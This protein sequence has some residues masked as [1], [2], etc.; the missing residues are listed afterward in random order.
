MSER[1]NARETASNKLKRQFGGRQILEICFL[2]VL[3][4]YPMRHVNVGGDLCDVGYN[5]GNFVFFSE[6][7]LGKTWFFSTYLA[8]AAGHLLTALPFGRTLMGINV[9][10]GVFVSILAIMGYLFCTRVLRLSPIASFAGEFV[11]ISMCW[12][13]TSLLYNYLTYVLFLACLILLYQGLAK[14]K[15]WMLVM[16]GACLG[17]N[18]FVRFSNLPEMG[19]IL[20]VWGFAIWEGREGHA[21]KGWFG[22]AMGKLVRYTAWCLL[23]YVG[24]LLLG[25]AWIGIRYGLSDYVTGIKLLFSMTE[26]AADYKP[27]SMIKGLIWPFWEAIYWVIRLAFFMVIALLAGLAGRYLP[28]ALPKEKRDKVKVPLAVL[29]LCGTWLANAAMVFWIFYQGKGGGHLTSFW[30]TSYDPIYWPCALFWMLALGIGLIEA[31]RPGNAK[32]NRFLGLALILIGMLTSL[33]SNNGIYPSFNNLFAFAPYVFAK[34][35]QFTRYLFRK[36][37]LSGLLPVCTTAW[38]FLVVC[39]VQ[40]ILFGWVF[41][42]C[43]STGIQNA[44][45]V[46]K[47]NRVLQGIKMNESRAIALEELSEFA[48]QQGL[49]GKEVILHGNVPA[50][51][52]YF[53][54]KPALHSWNDLKSFS[55]EVMKETMDELREELGPQGEKPV[56]IA[57][58]KYADFG[59]VAP[60]EAA[61]ALYNEKE[62]TEDLKWEL[63]RSFMGEY[64]YRKTFENDKFVVW[65]AP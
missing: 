24:I 19:L 23:G 54:M 55:Y 40:M 5:Y 43:E 30:Y 27:V 11:A 32:E 36:K 6:Q 47:N 51:A 20:A 44:D 33:G 58:K 18:V 60:G 26:S 50:I 12:C 28:Q 35:A 14:G 22:P 42:F 39:A 15:S 48:G 4:L 29:G 25:F 52:F 17:A 61:T 21:G 57:E 41:V 7:S 3:A 16:A 53:E 34:T 1:G 46:I 9:Y 63:I 10:T 45:T 65:Q 2:L 64:G 49:A 56:V 38:T 59:P 62:G 8:S 13:P 31:V 37:K